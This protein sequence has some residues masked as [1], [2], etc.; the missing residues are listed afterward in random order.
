MPR[1]MREMAVVLVF[2]TSFA[3]GTFG[4]RCGKEGWAVKTGTDSGVGLVN[5]ASPQPAN[6]SQ[7]IT[8]PA[9]S[10]RT[11]VLRPAKTLSLWSTPH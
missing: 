4:Q 3:V 6:I 10:P 1:F 5:L 7:L 2:T 9:P 8:L 11:A